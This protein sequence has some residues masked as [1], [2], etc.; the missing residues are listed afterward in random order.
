MNKTIPIIDFQG[1]IEGNQIER[2]VVARQFYDA[3]DRVGCLYIKHH[4]I[5]P[6]LIERSFAQS[7]AFFALPLEEKQKI[8]QD[9]YSPGVGYFRNPTRPKEVFGYVY[10]RSADGENSDASINSHPQYDWPVNPPLFRETILEFFQSCQELSWKLFQALA[11]GLKIPET[12]LT[13]AISDKN[14]Y[15][16]LI[17][18]FPITQPTQPGQTRFQAHRGSGTFGLIFQDEAKGL[19]ICT[20]DGEWIAVT[21]IP[22]TVVVIM[23]DLIQRWTNDRLVSTLHQVTVPEEEFYRTRSRYS[24]GF[25]VTPNY[26]AEIS[27]LEACVNENNP[28]KYSPISVTDYYKEWEQKNYG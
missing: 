21:S 19:E 2:E 6:D 8:A 14:C 23:E 4:G 28:P 17:H 11:I 12:V 7:Q 25:K 20:P 5:S 13:D 24:I 1:F 16:G 10:E 9:K 18:Y 15:I 27:C 26:D 22:G 3:L